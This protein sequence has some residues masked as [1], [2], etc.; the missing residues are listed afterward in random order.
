M[1]QISHIGYTTIPTAVGFGNG[2]NSGVDC[3][4]YGTKMFGLLIVGEYFD[5]AGNVLASDPGK[6]MVVVQ[7]SDVGGFEEDDW[8]TLATF[9]I[10]SI[11]SVRRTFQVSF[12]RSKRYVRTR[13]Y[14]VEESSSIVGYATQVGDI[15]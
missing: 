9:A 13:T 12:A 4:E 15:E 14:R 2:T 5:E 11:L 7:E 10:I 6:L 8:T 3:E 1:N